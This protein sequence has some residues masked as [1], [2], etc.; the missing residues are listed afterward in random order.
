MLKL[1]VPYVECETCHINV[2]IDLLEDHDY[3]QHK[4][5][6]K[7]CSSCHRDILEKEFKDHV[8]AHQFEERPS[9][10]PQDERK[11]QTISEALRRPRQISPDSEEDDFIEIRNEERRNNPRRNNPHEQA[12]AS[13]Q[14][15]G[16]SI[17][18]DIVRMRFHQNHHQN[19]GVIPRGERSLS[20]G[21][22]QRRI[23]EITALIQSLNTRRMRFNERIG[24]SSSSSDVDND[25]DDLG[26]E[27]RKKEK[28]DL[29][30]FKFD[31]SKSGQLSEESRTCQI[32]ICEFESGENVM[33]LPCLH[34]YHEP[35]IS[36][37]LQ[38]SDLCPMCK[39]HI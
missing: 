30:V 27:P 21:N 7:H 9:Y 10:A 14:F 1:V 16:G 13:V 39:S 37:W 4:S 34:K 2:R 15:A 23:L 18:P 3:R 20:R 31:K 5:A 24:M 29:P 25:E 22:Q 36:E 17:F 28:P 12:I 19:E 33:L 26:L 6:T 38:K 11:E 32:C 8:M 35:C